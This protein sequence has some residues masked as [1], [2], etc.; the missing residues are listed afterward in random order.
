M[1]TWLISQ[2]G[3]RQGHRLLSRRARPAASR[4]Y[5]Y[6]LMAR[7]RS[8]QA[9]QARLGGRAGAWTA[10][11]SWAWRSTDWR[12]AGWASA[13]RPDDRRRNM[14]SRA[15]PAAARTSGGSTAASGVQDAASR[16][17]SHAER[18]Q[19]WCGYVIGYW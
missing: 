9:S 7:W 18:A 10:A 3:A 19:T 2:G 11:T 13:R 6:R 15:T 4:P 14:L 17:L 5:Y 12:P 8:G 1:P 16:P